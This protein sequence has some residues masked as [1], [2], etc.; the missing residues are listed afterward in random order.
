MAFYLYFW[1]NVSDCPLWVD[2]K[3]ASDHAVVVTAVHL[4]KLPDAVGFENIVIDI[5]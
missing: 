1:P 4:F 5:A 2:Q 3:S